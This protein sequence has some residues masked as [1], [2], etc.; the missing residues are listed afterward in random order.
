MVGRA[1][2]GFEPGQIHERL[3]GRA[4]LALRLR[5]AVELALAIIAAADHGAHRAVGGQRDKGA[6]AHGIFLAITGKHIRDRRLGRCLQPRIQGRADC[7][8]AITGAG[9]LADLVGHPI[10]E[11]ARSRPPEYGKLAALLR[12]G[13]RIRA[14]DKSGVDHVVENLR[15]PP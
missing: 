2:P 11:I 13:D 5:R 1:Q 8:I 15:G 6:L 10:G 9:E 7:Q 12:R 4:R 14:G 3:E